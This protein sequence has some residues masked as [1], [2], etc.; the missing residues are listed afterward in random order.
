MSM[1]VH[2]SITLCLATDI[3]CT[4]G[5][6]WIGE[7]IGNIYVV[8]TILLEIAIKLSTMFDVLYFS[9]WLFLIIK[10]VREGSPKPIMNHVM[11]V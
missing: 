8:A 5:Q 10:T 7:D 3:F 6:C 1:T 11:Y 9:Y 2:A 4:L